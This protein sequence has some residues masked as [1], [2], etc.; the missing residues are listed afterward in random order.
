MQARVATAEKEGPVEPLEEPKSAMEALEQAAA[1][2]KP[3][4]KTSTKKKPAKEIKEKPQKKKQSSRRALT[5]HV[6]RRRQQDEDEEDVEEA[7]SVYLEENFSPEEDQGAY[8]EPQEVHRC[9]CRCSIVR[10]L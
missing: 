9:K 1:K 2:A 10:E 4:K 3:K 5:E 8:P 6:E 7:E